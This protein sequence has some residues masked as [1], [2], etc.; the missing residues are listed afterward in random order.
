MQL[1]CKHTH[2]QLSIPP[3]SV[4]V[5]LYNPTF[6]AKIADTF[7]QLRLKF[8]ESKTA[9]ESSS[10]QEGYD[11]ILT[12]VD[13][14]E[15]NIET[16]FHPR[17]VSLQALLGDPQAGWK[18]YEQLQQSAKTYKLFGV[19]L[20]HSMQF[21]LDTCVELID[22]HVEELYSSLLLVEHMFINITYLLLGHIDS[23]LRKDFYLKPVPSSRNYK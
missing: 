1:N 17:C 9:G 22:I 16:S 13:N 20:S 18:L 3:F 2:A 11:D 12:D 14:K 10:R 23:V 5:P 19:Q 15:E 6:V 4:V 8:E 7:K 21:L